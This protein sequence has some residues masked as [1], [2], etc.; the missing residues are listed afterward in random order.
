MIHA[1]GQT[2]MAQLGH[3][4]AAIAQQ[5]LDLLHA[6]QVLV[7][8]VAQ[9]ACQ[10]DPLPIHHTR[11]Q[12]CRDARRVGVSAGRH[13]P[14]AGRAYQVLVPQLAISNACEL[15]TLPDCEPGDRERNLGLTYQSQVRLTVLPRVDWLD[16]RCVARANRKDHLGHAVG[17]RD[18]R[19]TERAAQALPAV[20][21]DLKRIHPR[22]VF[23]QTCLIQ[24]Q[25]QFPK[26]CGL[27]PVRQ[28]GQL[29]KD[30]AGDR[31]EL[32]TLDNCISVHHPFLAREHVLVEGR[33][34]VATPLPVLARWQV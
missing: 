27:N 8:H 13:Q 19:V 34:H 33:Q 22:P 10:V 31:R 14:G 3:H 28:V 21:G 24:Q 29:D 15:A 6:A 26:R 5:A 20:Q 1:A 12:Q 16:Q 2:R 17:D 23:R 30:I 32:S 9:R 11:P 4:L 7:P 25:I 18:L